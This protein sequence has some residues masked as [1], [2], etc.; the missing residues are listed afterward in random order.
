MKRH[1][2]AG[3]L[4]ALLFT[5]IA[6][7]APAAPATKEKPKSKVGILI[8]NGKEPRF[9]LVKQAILDQLKREGFDPSNT[10][11]LI[12]DAGANNAK[13]ELFLKVILAENPDVLVPIGTPA[14]LAAAKHEK[15]KPIVFSLVY[16]PIESGIAKSWESSGNNT[17]GAS[18]YVSIIKFLR[19]VEEFM[20]LKRIAVLYTPGQKNSE[21]QLAAVSA[22]KQF[23]QSDIVAVQLR[24]P[25]DVPELETEIGKVNAIFLTAGSTVGMNMAKII[26]IA[27]KN[28]IP[29]LTHV[30]DFVNRGAMLGLGVD[31]ATVGRLTG[32]KVA[33]VLRKTDPSTIKIEYP[34]PEL[35]LNLKTA[36]A[37]KYD[38]PQGLKDWASKT[39]K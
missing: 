26:E 16:D 1:A 12:E 11:F 28:K 33:Q 35:T 25:V 6:A 22:M 8:W 21:L 7:A 30:E 34:A 38:V 14:A 17:T 2:Y 39:V 13:N 27:V 29:T 37:M 5:G 23:T 4:A 10:T 32:Q 18:T 24:G 15:K 19:R 20:P 31:S 36:A 3:A 9:G